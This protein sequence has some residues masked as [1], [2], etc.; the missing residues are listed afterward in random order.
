MRPCRP[1]VDSF[2]DTSPAGTNPPCEKGAA[3]AVL[4]RERPVVR[5]GRC[6]MPDAVK[7]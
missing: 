3:L 2:L 6:R 4:R 7:S 5:G 1:S